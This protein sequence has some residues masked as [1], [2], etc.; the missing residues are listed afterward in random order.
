[1]DTGA[2]QGSV[3]AG[4]ITTGFFEN[5]PGIRIEIKRILEGDL[6]SREEKGEKNV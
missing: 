3:D 1:V 2:R 6:V 5:V 4:Y